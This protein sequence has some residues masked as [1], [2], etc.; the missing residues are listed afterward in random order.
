MSLVKNMK[1]WLKIRKN[2]DVNDI[3]LLQLPLVRDAMAD[4]FIDRSAQNINENPMCI[5]RDVR[6]D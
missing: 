1:Q 5:D 6:A 3:A 2:T 4:Y